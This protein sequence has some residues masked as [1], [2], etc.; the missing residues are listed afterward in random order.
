MNS[1]FGIS[2]ADKRQPENIL[3]GCLLLQTIF[4]NEPSPRHIENLFSG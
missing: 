4:G 2:R 1:G 3:S